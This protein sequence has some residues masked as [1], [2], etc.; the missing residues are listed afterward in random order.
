[1]GEVGVRQG[2]V[3]HGGVGAAR[4]WLAYF[5]VLHPLPV[6]LTSGSSLPVSGVQRGERGRLPVAD[7]VGHVRRV[8]RGEGGAPW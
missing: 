8:L 6:F 7:H 5:S 4:T 1:M 3:F 2:V